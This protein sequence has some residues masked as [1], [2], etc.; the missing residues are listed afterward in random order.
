VGSKLIIEQQILSEMYALLLENA[1][2]RAERRFSIGPTEVIHPALVRGDVDLYPEYTGTALL[3]VLGLP[4]NND[5]LTVFQTVEREYA[6][7]FQLTWLA[8]A[9]TNN[10]QAIAMTKS[11]A[12]ELRIV[13]ISDFVAKARE[14]ATA[15]TPIVLTGPPEFVTRNDGLPGIRAAYGEFALD[16]RPVA[17]ANRYRQLNE[18]DADAVVAFGTDG[19]VGG[20]DLA[21]LIDDRQLFPPY[22]VAP[23]VRQRV[24]DREPGIR[25]ALNV[26]APRLNDNVLREMNFR[27]SQQGEATTE[28]ARNFLVEAGLIPGTVAQPAAN[29]IGNYRLVVRPTPYEVTAQA[30]VSL[31]ADNTV[32][33]SWVSQLTDTLAAPTGSGTWSQVGSSVSVTLTEANSQPLQPPAFITMTF[34]GNFIVAVQ[35]QNDPN[36]QTDYTFIINTGDHDPVVG[37]L[38]ALMANVPWLGF[39]D[40][41]PSNETYDDATRQAIVSFQQAQQVLPTG[42]VDAETWRALKNPQPPVP[43]P[44]APGG[45]AQRTQRRARGHAPVG[46]PSQKPIAQ[47]CAPTVGFSGGVNLRSGPSTDTEALAVVPAGT[48]L[49]ATGVNADRS[50]YQV[51]FYGTTGWVFGQIVAPQCVD[52]LPV[53]NAPVLPPQAKVIYLSFDDGP[54]GIWT[55]QILQVLQQ[56]NAKAVFFQI[57]QQVAPLADIVKSQTAAGMQ[58]GNHT[59]AH[60]SLAGV[61]QQVF[62]SVV[63]R[64]YDAQVAAGAH[65]QPGPR[66]LRPPYGATDGNTRG[67]ASA[68]GYRVVLWSIDPQDW[69]LPGTQQIV[70]N[71]LSNA[72]PGAIVLSHDGGGNRSQT[73][74]AYRVALPQLAAQGYTFA[75]MDCP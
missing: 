49:P 59:W 36:G 14:L 37:E 31:H 17:V 42:V 43:T 29:Y 75:P 73:L 51:N 26:L 4:T 27:A 34:D 65:T 15:G 2:F 5:A 25:D 71:I 44:A 16:F 24:L 9:N 61:S 74:D 70:N 35:V 3:D 53:I 30:N 69:A 11:R 58:I 23:V 7:R 13:T 72:Q 54:H 50:W 21:T 64:T 10:T 20:F 62:N 68:L 8:P 52:G 40:P 48:I 19:E 60:A 33:I 18:G 1:G 45:F 22:Q 28:I 32:G 6:S 57:G 63:S 38:H 67:W 12:A 46:V 41:G 39:T 47:A 55:S 66:C 56:N